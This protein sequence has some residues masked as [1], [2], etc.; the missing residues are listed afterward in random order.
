MKTLSFLALAII[1]LIFWAGFT[2]IAAWSVVFLWNSALELTGNTEPQ[3]SFSSVWLVV[4][5]VC[6]MNVLLRK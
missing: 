1:M 4:L 5:I 2:M 3:M 6:I